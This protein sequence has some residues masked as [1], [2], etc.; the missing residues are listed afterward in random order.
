VD[1][2]PVVESK[3]RVAGVEIGVGCV[4][5]QVRGERCERVCEVLQEFE[6]LVS[7]AESGRARSPG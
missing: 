6:Y 4:P 3:A 2:Q 5:L 1:G 7:R